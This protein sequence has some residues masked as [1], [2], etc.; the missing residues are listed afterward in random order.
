MVIDTDKIL[1]KVKGYSKAAQ[2]HMK[3]A[4][5]EVKAGLDAVEKEAENER[6]RALTNEEVEKLVQR[7]RILT[8]S[9]HER[10]QRLPDYADFRA[11]FEDELKEK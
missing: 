3:A 11:A 6:K 8:Y 9:V 1:E 10:L 7:A 2:E 4:I 5:E